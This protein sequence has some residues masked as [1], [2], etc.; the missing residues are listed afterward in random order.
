MEMTENMSNDSVYKG[1]YQI[2][3]KLRFSGPL[4]VQQARGILLDTTSILLKRLKFLV[5]MG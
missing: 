3:A 2:Q 1:V 4:L 5:T